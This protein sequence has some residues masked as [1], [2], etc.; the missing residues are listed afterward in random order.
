MENGLQGPSVSY[1]ESLKES[2]VVVYSREGSNS[3][4]GG[5][6]ENGEKQLGWMTMACLGGG[7]D[8]TCLHACGVRREARD[9]PGD[10]DLNT[11]MNVSAV[12]MMEKPRAGAR[13]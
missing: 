10:F 13:W 11:W 7:T 6:S 12:T 1:Q 8:R 4:Q 9:D 5:C 3:G 2:S